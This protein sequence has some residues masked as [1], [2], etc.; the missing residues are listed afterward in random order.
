[1]GAPPGD[2]GNGCLSNLAEG[3]NGTIFNPD[4]PADCPYITAVGATMLPR[5]GTVQDA[6]LTM[7]VPEVAPHF[8]SAGGF[9][10]FYPAPSYQKAAVDKYLAK[11]VPDYPYYYANASGTN[12]G[13]NGGIYARGGRG[14]PDVAANGAYLNAFVAG[15]LGQWFGT[16]LAA[17]IFASVITLVS[18]PYRLST[19]ADAETRST[20]SVRE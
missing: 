13:E 8:S 4:Y 9:S 20:R 14:Y 7:Y 5:N 12:Y 15:E 16:S 10:N 3:L 18:S 17:P 2:P 19:N 1:M 11:Y 6:E